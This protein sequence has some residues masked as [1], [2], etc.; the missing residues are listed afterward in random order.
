MSNNVMLQGRSGERRRAKTVRRWRNA[1][2]KSSLLMPQGTM[3][4]IECRINADGHARDFH[5]RRSRKFTR[6]V[7]IYRAL[8]AEP[9]STCRTGDR[10]RSSCFGFADGRGGDV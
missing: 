9:L 3:A 1:S 6:P 5:A 10:T 7:I 8:T 2:A 4:V